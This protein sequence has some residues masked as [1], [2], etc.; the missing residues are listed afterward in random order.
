MDKTRISYLLQ[1]VRTGA[2]T[3]EE[4]KELEEFWEWAQHDQTLF[5]TLSES[6]KETIRHSM[7]REITARIAALETLQTG[8]QVRFA[9]PG[10]F[11][12]IAAS[13]ILV[14]AVA[15]LW[16][17]FNDPKQVYSTGYGEHRII[18][19]PDSSRVT[20]NG[21]STIRYNADWLNDDDR[22]VWIEGEAFFDVT[23]TIN[24]QRFIVHTEDGVEVQV[25][26]TRFN[27][28]VRRG[29]TEV[30]LE[31]G[32]VTLDVSSM[33]EAKNIT[34]IPGD[35]VT[36]EKDAFVKAAVN[37]LHY[38]AWKNHKLYFDQ[39]TLREV[40]HILEDT[41]GIQA[42]FADENLAKR[43]L[44]GQIDS[45][46]ASDILAAVAESLNI[47]AEHEGKSVVFH[48]KN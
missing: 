36:V 28:K 12:K 3:P 16:L 24:H 31:E 33:V 48:G 43:K 2:C 15:G 26:G 19:L 37:P 44:S 9:V 35:M 1:Q 42:A 30:V 6:E 40:S 17:R 39:T 47:V 27:V 8:K 5:N 46:N 22:K 13:F 14:M 20:L 10:L 45:R 32:K 29:Q 41:Y 11:L 18:L 38:S 7:L 25:L 4:N 21:N 23:H 34:L